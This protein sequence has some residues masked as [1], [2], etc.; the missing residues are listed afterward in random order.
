MD[1]DPL[2]VCCRLSIWTRPLEEIP[3]V[4]PVCNLPVRPVSGGDIFMQPST[5]H[6]LQDDFDDIKALF[7]SPSYVY[8]APNYHRKYKGWHATAFAEICFGKAEGQ[9][10]SC[11]NGKSAHKAKQVV[12]LE[13]EPLAVHKCIAG[14]KG[15]FCKL[16]WYMIQLDTMSP[17]RN[18]RKR[19]QN[20]TSCMSEADFSQA[21]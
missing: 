4:I 10:G 7:V 17:S 18:F 12:G 14:W 9:A 6:T 21:K 11:H 13:Y 8:V 2:T 20:I 1:T 15:S 16:L 3:R 5:E 19:R